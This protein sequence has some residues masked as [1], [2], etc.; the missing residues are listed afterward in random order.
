MN[1]RV[2]LYDSNRNFLKKSK[3]RKEKALPGEYVLVAHTI[4]VNQKGQILIQKRVSSKALW[5]SLWD[6][7]CSG[8]I[9]AG[10]TS[11]SGM[12]RELFEELGVRVDLSTV[13]PIL[14]ASYPQGFSDYYVIELDRDLSDF[15]IASK[16]IQAIKWVYPT[17]LL[18]LL[19]RGDFVPYDPTFLSAL[20]SLYKNGS[21]IKLS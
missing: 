12:E 21:E 2:D 17:Q 8:G 19:D 15:K 7:S 18:D 5:P 14:T 11:S 13:R 1:E 4:I 20:F 10:E 16:E 3:L 6:L 9:V